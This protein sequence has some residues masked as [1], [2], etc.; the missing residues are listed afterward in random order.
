MAEY[1]ANVF[2]ETLRDLLVEETKFLLS[3]G[4]DVEKVK[5]DLR[6][7]H[8]LLMKA[9]RE[10]RDSPTL[11][12]YIS[13]LKDLAFKAENLLEKYAVEVQSKR[14]GQKSLKEKFQRYI[15]I[16][17]EC[18][19]VQRVGKEACDII[20]ALDKLTKELKS[21][22]DQQGSLLSKQE[23]EQ[24]RLLRQTYAHEVEH[25]FVGMERDIQI[26]VS[27]VKDETRKKR[28]VKIYGMGGLG[29]TTLARKVYNHI[30]LQS[31]ARAWVCI[32]QQFQP[33]AVFGDILKQ[34]DRNADIG[35]ME[36]LVRGI[37]NLLKERKCLV[38]IDDIWNNDDWE[39]IRQ[40]FPV[41]CNVILTT[42]YESI[43]NQQSDPHELKFLTKDEGWA[44]LQ[45]VVDLS[46]G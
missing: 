1:L 35:G 7:I 8:A 45:K 36:E 23:D 25:D 6:S 27:K 5:G 22:L 30:D 33:K 2:M 17:C 34:L 37:H 15:C 24:Q 18:Y 31:Y 13:Q 10:R 26:L 21:E 12:L 44:L 42:R 39:I 38:V 29:K 11:K 9:D 32:T 43:A 3:V 46:P 19:S 41:N 20:P 14:Q 28:V 40:A 4:G 16:M